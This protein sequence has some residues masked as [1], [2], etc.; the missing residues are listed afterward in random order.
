[1]TKNKKQYRLNLNTQVTVFIKDKYKKKLPKHI[2]DFDKNKDGSYTTELWE[3]VNI[4]GEDLKM[5]FGIP[6]EMNEII[7]PADDLKEI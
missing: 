4:F 3:L 7:I 2:V 5:G 1:M 6:F